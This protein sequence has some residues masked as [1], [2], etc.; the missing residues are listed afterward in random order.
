MTGLLFLLFFAFMLLG[1]PVALAIGASTLLALNAQGVPLMVVT[2]QMF[3]GSTPLHWSPF[4]C[5]SWP[6]T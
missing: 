6:A 5:S 4:Q 2:Q 3:Q 1:V